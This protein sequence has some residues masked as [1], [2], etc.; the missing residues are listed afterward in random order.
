MAGFT[1]GTLDARF[2]GRAM[3]SII[4][5]LLDGEPWV[6]YRV[7]LDLLGQAESEPD[8][9]NA[10]NG[11]LRDPSVGAILRGLEAW[12]GEA[13]SSHKSAGQPY[14]RLSFIADLGFRLGDPCISRIVGRVMEHQSREGPFQLPTN[15][16]KHFG[17]SGSVQWAWSL[18]DAPIIVYSLSK[19]GLQGDPRVEKAAEYLVSLVREN[20]WPCTVSK[21]LGGFRGPGRKGDPCPYATLAMLKMMAQLG[22]WRD[23]KEAHAGAECLLGLWAQS[24]ERHPYMFYMGTDFRKL[25]A[26][27]V[28]YDILHIADVLTQFNWLRRDGRLREMTDLIRSRAGQNGAYTPESEWKAWAGWDFGQK[29]QPSRWLTFLALRVIKRL[30]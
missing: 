28:W 4:N 13:L 21:E 18:C 26:P 24:R 8:V 5:W 7:R 16:P 15:I 17:G 22:G 12:P 11:M 3:N 1:A 29:K 10:R 25:K 2:G 9:A 27:F 19:L 30:E 14:H 23:G 6:E 20:G